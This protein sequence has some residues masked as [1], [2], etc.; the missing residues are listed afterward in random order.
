MGCSKFAT[1]AAGKAKQEIVGFSV[2]AALMLGALM[3]AVVVSPAARAVDFPSFEKLPTRVELPDPLTLLDGNRVTTPADWNAKRKPE[4]QALF[5]HY[6]YGKLPAKPQRW[7]VDGPSFEDP[8]YLDGKATLREETLAFY[9]PD[10]SQRLRVLVI[11]PNK[12]G[13][14]PMFV[15]MNFCGNHTVVA[16]PR[17]QIP[18]SWVYPSCAGV[19]N[20]RSTEKGRGGQADVWNVDLIVSRGYGLATFYSGDIDPDTPDFSDGIEPSFYKPGQTGP[21]PDD[22][23]AIAAWAWGYHRVVDYL[24]ETPT[25][26]VDPKR[27][28]AVGHSRNGKTTLLAAA[29]D[30]RIS[31]AIPHQAGCGGTAPSRGKVGESVKQINER[32]PHWFCDEFTRFNDEPARLPFDQHCLV[33]LCAPRPVLFSNAVEDTWANPDGQYEMLK[34]ADP[35]YKLLGAGGLDSTQSPELNK[36]IKSRLGYFLRPGK[37]SMNRQDWE[38]FLDFADAHAAPAK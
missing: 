10:L 23:G 17:V 8:K 27:I 6:M 36:L 31:L 30:E 38:A 37:H 35:V 21:A 15:A 20:N 34:A 1:R 4:L 18:T 5:Q 12:D 32:F 9:G 24:L 3:A 33:A 22:A 13:P 7:A 2:R 11:R 26:K 14:V 29:M 25:L 28:A 19:V 16:D